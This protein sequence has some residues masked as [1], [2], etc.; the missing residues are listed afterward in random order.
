M[1]ATDLSQS[2]IARWQTLIADTG[3]VEW[4][5]ELIDRRLTWALQRLDTAPLRD[6][7]QSALATMAA[8][9]TE[10]VA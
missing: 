7:V 2:D 9:C 1:T 8:A 3:T 6:D 5:E 10:R 4:I